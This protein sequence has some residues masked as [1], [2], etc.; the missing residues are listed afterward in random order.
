MRNIN[1]SM[2]P[3]FD[4]LYRAMLNVKDS[5]NRKVEDVDIFKPFFKELE[6]YQ[7]HMANSYNTSR[8]DKLQKAYN[9]LPENFR[10]KMRLHK[11]QY[12]YFFKTIDTYGVNPVT[13]FYFHNW[14]TKESYLPPAE[15]RFII[16]LE[17]NA[18]SHSGTF[19]C[20]FD[21]MQSYFGF[22]KFMGILD[23]YGI[24]HN[25]KEALVFNA[26]V[27]GYSLRGI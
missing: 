18:K 26:K 12:K 6:Y 14:R 19:V 11:L 13:S 22:K 10:K 2:T 20:D 23:D 9:D 21:R 3:N 5:D 1:N 27:N 8:A 15:D 16:S 25:I 17:T 7:K 24:Q 4:K